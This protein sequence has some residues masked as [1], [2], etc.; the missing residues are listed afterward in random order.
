MTFSYFFLVSGLEPDL[1]GPDDAAGVDDV[2]RSAVGIL[3][4]QGRPDAV[5]DGVAPALILS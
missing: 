3:H 2:R 1:G 5:K 4:C